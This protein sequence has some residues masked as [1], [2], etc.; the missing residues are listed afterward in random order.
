MSSTGFQRRDASDPAGVNGTPV[1]LDSS[2]RAVIDLA[3]CRSAAVI[4]APGS[5]KTATLVEL[6]A[7]RVL[8]LGWAPESIVAITPNRSTATRLRDTLAVR[9][10][11]PTNGPLARSV[12]SLAFEIVAAAASTTGEPPPRLITGGEQ[13]SDI[14]HLLAGHLD[15]GTG[16]EWPPE[17]GPQVRALGEFR[18]ELR[19][20]LMR[21]TEYGV[22]NDD[23]RRLAREH[24]HPEWAA[25]AQFFDEYAQVSA[26]LRPG[27]Y[28]SAEL[29][30]AAVRALQ[31]GLVS[32]RI[33]ALRL[34]VV[35]DLQEATESTISLLAALA[36]RG[37]TVV[38]FGD[39]DVAANAFRGGEP[40]SLG[41]LPSV[42]GVPDA[43]VLYLGTV[44]RQGAELRRL[45]STIVQRIGTAAAGPQRA[46]LAAGAPAP[47]AIVRIQAATP[48]RQW[49][50]IA[51]LLRG[52]HLLD[53]VPFSSMAVVLRSGAQV[54]AVARALALADVPTR[55]SVGG[56]P[57]RDDVAARAM[58]TV[59]DVGMGRSPLTPGAATDL[60]LG[61]FGGLDRLG[62]RRLRLALRAEELSGGGDRTSDDLLVDGLA[63]PGRFITID[64]RVAR[65]ADRMA[66]MLASVRAAVVRGGTIEEV[67]WLVWER[68]GLATTWRDQALGAGITAP[69]ANRNLDGVLALFTAARR[70][71]ERSPGSPP[72]VFLDGVLDAEVPEDTLSPQSHDEAVLVTTPSGVVGLEVDIVVV[73]GV[74]E[75]SW[76]NL[77]LRGSLLDPQALVDIVTG[78]DT[79]TVNARA[80]VLGDELRMF[81][82][83]VSRARRR[84][85]VSAVA[86]DD[87][88][89]SVFFS[90]L[91]PDLPVT[92]TSTMRPLSLRRLTGVLRRELVLPHR[93]AADRAAAAS[94]LA[95]MA[96]DGL[97][98]ADPAEWHGLLDPSTDAPLYGDDETV[99]VSPSQLERVEKSALDWFVDRVAGS[100]SSTAMGLGTVIHWAMETATDHTVDGLAAAIESR[101][102]ELSFESPWI[103]EFQKRAARTLAAGVAE[104]LA[105]FA[106]DGKGLAAAEARFELALGRAKLSGSIDRVERAADGS[107]VIVDLKTGNP[108][109]RADDIARHAQLRAYQLAYA[110][111]QLDDVLD[112]LGDHKPGGAKLLFVKKGIA[113]RSYREAEQAP[114]D[115]DELDAFRQRILDAAEVMA[116]SGFDGEVEVTGWAAVGNSAAALT[117]VKAVTSD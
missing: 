68:S 47:K 74:Q 60:L 71:V 63:S 56:R 21:A 19:D 22:S 76:P 51:R 42:L 65:S 58:L 36:A 59:V 40:D 86:N 29:V 32:E 110:A 16:P 26:W 37:V 92:D 20:L 2:Q 85:I 89:P 38:A 10:A 9:L 34:V 99:P 66:T 83:A 45:T 88:A 24:D 79:S 7:D 75:G 46:A 23:L 4:G 13:D 87:E 33:E 49:A 109:T 50:S 94:A 28:D 107:V 112:P 39:P 41:R 111:G 3:P 96:R 116:A 17:L 67:L 8:G 82:L 69:E 70:F 90:L 25:A 108:I 80:Q 104:Y 105:D 6:V 31:S 77:R 115:D 103:S 106:R 62:L 95:T 91:P 1:A 15:D 100:R 52:S 101:W 14:S 98:G 5:G 57:L 43:A 18:T 54:P 35:D 11:V 97:P 93:S 72:S 113:G 78:I 61:P 73:A 102:A 12:G 84:V 55:T 30:G 53:G 114:L 48:S 44:H 64:H 27:Q 81:A 117:R